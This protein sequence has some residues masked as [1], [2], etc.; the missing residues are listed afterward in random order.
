MAETS[1]ALERGPK[2]KNLRW[3]LEQPAYKERFNAML[4][5]RAPQ[6]MASIINIASSQNFRNV[7]PTS[8]LS[9]AAVAATLD[10]PIDKNLGFAWIIPYKNLAQFQIGWKGIVQLALRSG[11]YSG[12]NAFK[13]NAEALGGYDN[14]GDPII[15]WEHLDK[16]KQAA[17]YAFA[18][19]LNSGFSKIVYWSKK[20]V[21][22]H[23][24]R[25][26]QAFKA[27]RKDSPWFSD[28]DKMALKTVVMNALRS[29]GVL[30]V[31]MRQAAVLD[32][33]AAIDID[34]R[35]IY[36][37]N[38]GNL[39]DENE[40]TNGVRNGDDLAAKLAVEREQRAAQPE[41]EQEPVGQSGETANGS[42]DKQRSSLV[43]VFNALV[44][45]TTLKAA[46]ETLEIACGKVKPESVPDDQV[47][48]ATRA[49]SAALQ[50]ARTE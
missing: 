41:P 13:V 30:S 50:R 10:L 33:S 45:A 1:Q 24:A 3:Y 42:I 25:Y 48:A 18:W 14:I 44:E 39:E 11:Q 20:E 28:F 21:E 2:E 5:E 31:E 46:K 6:F 34:A 22:A 19:R 4:G 47:I 40:P 8:I 37:D 38:D 16:T 35:E 32:Q 27:G 29:W 26:S 49:L 36:P 9:A 15:L 7:E 43:D 12:I 17:G 23:A